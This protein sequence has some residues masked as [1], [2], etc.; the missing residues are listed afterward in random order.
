[1]GFQDLKDMKLKGIFGLYTPTNELV[2]LLD[3]RVRNH[4]S[5]QFVPMEK[6]ATGERFEPRLDLVRVLNEMEVLAWSAKG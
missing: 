4:E 3:G 1:M 5:W 2:Q 6:L